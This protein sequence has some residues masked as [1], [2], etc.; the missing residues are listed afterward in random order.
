MEVECGEAVSCV[1]GH[2]LQGISLSPKASL[3]EG[4]VGVAMQGGP[5]GAVLAGW[6]VGVDDPSLAAIA[7]P[8]PVE[9]IGGLV[10]RRSPAPVRHRRCVSTGWEPSASTQ[11]VSVLR[12]HPGFN[13][14]TSLSPARCRYLQPSARCV[15]TPTPS[16]SSTEDACRGAGCDLANGLLTD[17]R[18]KARTDGHGALVMTAENPGIPGW[19]VRIGRGRDR[20]RPSRN[21]QV[22]AR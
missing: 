18:G 17:S 15:L 19:P 13:V 10:E 1:R 22:G 3:S 14:S 9:V 6:R 12:A 16:A 5:T 11:D 2:H 8:F 7:A 4:L 21:E 20:F